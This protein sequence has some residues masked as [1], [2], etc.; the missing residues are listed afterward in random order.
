METTT[1][2]AKWNQTK[3]E[4]EHKFIAFNDNNHHYV[5]DWNQ[6]TVPG[7]KFLTKCELCKLNQKLYNTSWF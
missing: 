6:N 7:L 3:G 5:N 1:L 4:L 2:E